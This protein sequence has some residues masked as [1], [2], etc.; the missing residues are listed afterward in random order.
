MTQVFSVPAATV[1]SLFAASALTTLLPL[2]IVIVLGM[3]KKLSVMPFFV[4]LLSFFVSQMLFRVPLLSFLGTL[5]WYLRFASNPFV[6]AL[7]IG[8]LSAG[9]F[10]ETARL[11]GARVFCRGR[12]EWRDAVSFGLGHGLCEVV[13]LVGISYLNSAVM[14]VLLNVGAV[15]LLEGIAPGMTEVITGQFASLEPAMLA[16]GVG[17]RIPAMVFHIFASV[18]VF[19]GVRRRQIAWYLLAVLLHTLL[20]GTAA[21]LAWYG[22]VWISEGFLWAFG[23]LLFILLLR[24][25]KK[26]GGPAA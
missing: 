13:L 26:Y 19:S 16:V 24:F 7:L 23:A 1:A 17:E 14:A 22:N 12:L 25:R 2:G 15:G 20:N 3:R 10:E 18:M 4:G 11:L 8:G 5:P 6:S 9:L 21:L